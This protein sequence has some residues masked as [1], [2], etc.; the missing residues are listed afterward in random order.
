M[1]TVIGGGNKQVS[2]AAL[3]TVK[4]GQRSADLPGPPQPPLAAIWSGRILS[5]TWPTAATAS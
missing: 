3:I 2:L 5:G 1:V 4:L